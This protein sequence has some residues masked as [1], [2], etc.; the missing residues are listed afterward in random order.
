MKCSTMPHEEVVV[1]VVAFVPLSG[2]MPS[3]VKVPGCYVLPLGR[4]LDLMKLCTCKSD[5]NVEIMCANVVSH[6][7]QEVGQPGQ[8]EY[9]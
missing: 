3:L 5:D 7:T 2:A 9:K 4:I 6:K 1:A 8:E